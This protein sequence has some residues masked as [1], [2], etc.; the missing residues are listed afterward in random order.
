[1]KQTYITYHFRGFMFGA[2]ASEKWHE[3]RRIPAKLPNNCYMFEFYDLT[4]ASVDGETLSGSAK[5]KSKQY[6]VGE[7]RTLAEIPATQD[8]RILRTDLEC[9]NKGIGVKC[10]PG[11]WIGFDPNMILLPA[12]QFKYEERYVR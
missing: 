5:N 8:N 7:K 10:A 3:D 11:N 2:Q 12:S 4:T 9:N 1:M 6:V